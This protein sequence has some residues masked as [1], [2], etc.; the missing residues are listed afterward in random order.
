MRA[1]ALEVNDAGLL[2][3]SE[4][5][6]RPTALGPGLALFEEGALLTGA[7]AAAR[8]QLRPRAVCDAFW[9]HLD[10]EPVGRPYPARVSHAD[11]A[12]AHL[13]ARRDSFRDPSHPEGSGDAPRLDEAEVVLAV[14]G[15]WTPAALG[16]L[17]SVTRAAGLDVR[18]LVD[19]AVA[20]ACF[21]PRHSR[22]LHLDLTRHRT[23]LTRLDGSD[24]VRRLGVAD[25]EGLGTAA[26]EAAYADHLARRF[27]AETR[28]DPRH[29]G[30][31]DQALHDAIPGW[32]RELHSLPTCPA[33]LTGGRLE[34]RLELSLGDFARA[35]AALHER[36]AERVTARA[37]GAPPLLLL[38]A[39]ASRQPGLASHL[40]DRSGL[41]VFE[42]PYDVTVLAALRHHPRIR[43]TGDALPFVTRLPAWDAAGVAPEPGLAPRE[44]RPPTHLVNAGVAHLLAPDGLTLGT[45]PPPG[46]RGLA[47]HR[48]GI[49]PHHCSLVCAGGDVVLEDHGA[50]ATFLNGA[51]L[52]DRV[53]VRTGDRLRLGEAGAELLFVAL[54][55]LRPR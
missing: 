12:F 39:R 52:T 32:L 8:A 11:L 18:G 13:R 49:A 33:V 15:F 25:V 26:F 9:D 34:H 14:P 21:A 6:P 7:A 29:S 50:G 41:E 28:F 37:E 1:L 44:G 54:E 4:G 22:L 55:E 48:D 3:L 5:Q 19:A 27:V 40:R 17:L 24:G 20:A 36:L 31:S 42:L 30:P 23:V 2:A 35:G 53:R 43:R 38:S 45:T 47:L 10:T 46:R 51:P 16:L